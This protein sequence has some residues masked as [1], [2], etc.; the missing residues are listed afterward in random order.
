MSVYAVKGTADLT[1]VDTKDPILY[2]E[3]AVASQMYDQLKVE[4][5]PIGEMNQDRLKMGKNISCLAMSST[6]VC[7]IRF[8]NLSNGTI[9]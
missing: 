5:I 3:G 4:A 7:T 8:L 1:L 2:L 6:V 9:K